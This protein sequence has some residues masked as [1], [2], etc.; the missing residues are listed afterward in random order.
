MMLKISLKVLSSAL[1]LVLVAALWGVHLDARAAGSLNRIFGP[2]RGATAIEISQQ[3]YPTPDTA[4]A[5]LLA[6]Q[7]AFPDALTAS[8]LAGILNAPILLVAPGSGLST[9]VRAELDRV[10]PPGAKVILVGGTSAL[11]PAI[12][13]ELNGTYIVERLAGATRYE[14]AKLVKER[15]DV[16]RGSPATAAFIARGDTYP[17]SLSISSYAAFSYVPIILVEPDDIP[18]VVEPILTSTIATP[19]VL[20]GST[21]VSDSVYAEVESRTKNI[22]TRISGV[23]RFATSSAIAE[24]FF[25]TPFAVAIATG[26]NFPDALAGG[27]LAGLSVLSPAGLPLLLVEPSSVP[28]AVNQYLTSHAATIDDVTSGYLFGGEAAVTLETELAIENIL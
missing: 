10:V 11:D 8:S 15:A 6:R 9:S 20:G 22:A 18:A 1:V 26:R 2:N 17:D 4:G 25:P 14:T 12:E 19:Y 27:V 24:Y 23:D 28:S 3:L 16:V 7:D 13:V 21:A 5:V